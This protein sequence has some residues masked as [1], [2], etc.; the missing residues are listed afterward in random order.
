MRHVGADRRGYGHPYSGAGYWFVLS[1]FTMAA[2]ALHWGTRAHLEHRVAGR[3][4]RVHFCRGRESRLRSGGLPAGAQFRQDLA[5]PG[6]SDQVADPF[7][8]FYLPAVRPMCLL[9]RDLSRGNA[10]C[11]S[12]GGNSTATV[13]NT[14]DDGGHRFGG[15]RIFVDL[16]ADLPSGSGIRAVLALAVL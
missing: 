7:S 2:P 11:W 1:D 8:G 3:F 5:G 6:V 10:G 15:R 14:L 9:Q 4:A 12:P 13:E 16:F